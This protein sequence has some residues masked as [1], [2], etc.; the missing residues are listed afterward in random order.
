MSQNLSDVSTISLTHRFF[1]F[2]VGWS[3]TRRL[4]YYY[5]IVT[6]FVEISD[7]CSGTEINLFCNVK[8]LATKIILHTSPFR[9]IWLIW[10]KWCGPHPHSGELQ[11]H[12]INC[13]NWYPK[14]FCN[15]TLAMSTF[16]FTHNMASLKLKQLQGFFY[17]Q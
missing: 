13:R 17:D 5:I 12:V 1:P 9:E 10:E 8:K 4:S 3:K 7:R 2:D 14:H 6:N 16:R 11:H 15:F